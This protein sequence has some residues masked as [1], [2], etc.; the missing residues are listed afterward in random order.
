M[1]RKQACCFCRTSS[2][3]RLNWELEKSNG[4]R[5]T[6]E[7]IPTFPSLQSRP[8]VRTHIFPLQFPSMLAGDGLLPS[9]GLQRY[10]VHKNPLP[11]LMT[12]LG[13]WVSRTIIRH[14]VPDVDLSNEDSMGPIVE[15][16]RISFP[17]PS[18]CVVGVGFI[19]L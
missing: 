16:I 14:C 4:P 9:N 12:S 19:W 3:A 8:I 15:L 11:P 2:T 6:V 18:G 10:L 5:Q 1:I 17:S 13:T 7:E